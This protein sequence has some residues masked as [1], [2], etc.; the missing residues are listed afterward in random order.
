MSDP[1]VF[2]PRGLSDRDLA[3]L[4]AHRAALADAAGER[5][6][7]GL[8]VRVGDGDA[9][10]LPPALARVVAAAL[11]EV[12]DG[13]AVEVRTVA[14]ELSTQGAA[15]VLGVSR[16][17]VVK[18]VDSGE[19]PARRVGTH[20]RLR[21]ADVLAYRDRMRATTDGALRELS[22]EAQALGLYDADP[23]MPGAEGPP[24]SGSAAG[25][26]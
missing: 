4:H 15:D 14:E 18:L 7:A 2:D 20:R 17:F 8:S 13:H 19:L 10:D 21:R 22:D 3:A 5:P 24:T 16:P 1:T 11:A 12:A 23:R 9:V 6:G 25:R 26:A